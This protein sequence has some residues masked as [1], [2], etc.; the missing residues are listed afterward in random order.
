MKRFTETQKWGDPWY[1]KLKPE[2]KL[3]MQWVLDSCDNAG[4]IDLDLEL[5]S[6]QIGYAMTM[7]TLSLLGDRVEK[8]DC[9]KYF[10]P[11]FIGFQYGEL[12]TECK[13]HN[14]VFASL[15]KHGLKGYP[16]G[17]HRDQEKDKDKERDKEKEKESSVYST[18]SRIALHYLN[19]KSGRSF[20][21]SESSL[22]VIQA[23]LSEQGVDIAGVRLM[24]DRQ[25]RRW[26][27]TKQEE[28]LRPE[29]LF[30][31]QKFDGYYAAKDLPIHENDERTNGQRIDRSIGTANEGLASQYEGL[32]RLVKPPVA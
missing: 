22:S 11:K 15:E 8:L 28:Y 24:I 31:K 3:L 23:R 5:A 27:G 30:G 13:A 16:K 12:S 32:G 19:E 10:I 2:A 20:R 9:G 1:R 26:K 25:C 17:I 4:V 14:P 18:E 6:F 29:T 21:E 7:E